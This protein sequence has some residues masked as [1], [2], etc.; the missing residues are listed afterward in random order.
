M[1]NKNI[2]CSALLLVAT[3]ALLVACGGSETVNN[4]DNTAVE[5][6][7]NEKLLPECNKGA[8][9]SLAYV[10]SDSTMRVCFDAEWYVING[11]KGEDG[12]PGE[13]GEVGEPGEN[14]TGCT[15]SALKDKSGLKLTCDG[16]SIGVIKNGPQ[17][18]KGE[19]GEDCVPCSSENLKDGSGYI[20]ICE[21]DTVVTIHNGK[22]NLE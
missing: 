14:G 8:E 12:E 5:S 18:E 13:K 6:Y 7:K 15:V 3:T 1:K 16:D 11:E 21:G 22:S 4:Y 9:G 10:R 2:F 17:G 19:P 20:I